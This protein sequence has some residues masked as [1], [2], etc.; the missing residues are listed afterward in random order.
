MTS[1][2]QLQ[3]ARVCGEL[4]TAVAIA[5]ATIEHGG[6]P[7]LE[8]LVERLRQLLDEIGA[9]PA[10]EQRALLPRLMGLAEEIEALGGTIDAERRRCREALAKG[11]ASARAIA[12]YAKTD[13]N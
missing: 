1:S 13:L 11:G 2:A 5:R 12:A 8:A 3:L 10:A 7:D 9:V 6:N 4:V